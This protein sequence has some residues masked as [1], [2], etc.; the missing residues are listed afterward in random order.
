[1]T[2]Y[3]RTSIFAHS[4]SSR[5]TNHII[6][7]LNLHMLIVACV[8]DKRRYVIGSLDIRL[9]ILLIIHCE[10]NISS[11]RAREAS[12]LLTPA[13]SSPSLGRTLFYGKV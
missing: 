10:K 4:H 5:I 13:T 1:M 11:L 7:N 2:V 12:R 9:D 3:I 8:N 6:T